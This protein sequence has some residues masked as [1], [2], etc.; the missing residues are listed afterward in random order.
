MKFP[1]GALPIFR[2]CVSFREESLDEAPLPKVMIRDPTKT[3]TS[4][5]TNIDT[6]NNGLEKV[7]YFKIWPYVVSIP[8]F[9][10]VKCVNVEPL[11][12]SSLWQIPPLEYVPIKLLLYMISRARYM[13]TSQTN[14]C[15]PKATRR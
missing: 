2:G 3:I 9:L 1:I 13:V 5:K 10:G 7:D 12:T 4:L 15:Y 8:R 14:M 11:L 6:Q